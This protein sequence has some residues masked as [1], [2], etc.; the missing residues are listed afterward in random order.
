MYINSKIHKKIIKYLN[1]TN[2]INWIC[3]NKTIYDYFK[4]SNLLS[5][6][7]EKFK[8]KLEKNILKSDNDY[9]NIFLLYDYTNRF[10]YNIII[11]SKLIIPKMFYDNFVRNFKNKKINDIILFNSYFKY[12]YTEDVD[13]KNLISINTYVGRQKTCRNIYIYAKNL[14]IYDNNLDNNIYHNVTNVYWTYST[15]YLNYILIH[16]DENLD[17]TELLKK[18]PSAKNIIINY[19]IYLKETF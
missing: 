6:K 11:K 7:I 12:D 1:S 9:S 14:Y 18:F 19:K 8:L 4:K 3:V 17:I 5:S 10:K 2:L 15:H 16:K 13:C